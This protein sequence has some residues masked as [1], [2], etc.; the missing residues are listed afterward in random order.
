MPRPLLNELAA[1]AVVA[2]ERSF[3]RAAKELGV[4]PSALSHAMRGLEERL[5]VR[6][7]ARTTRSVATTEA[8]EQLLETL[9]P[10]LAEIDGGIAALH[11]AQDMPRGTVRVTAVKHA[12]E[13]LLMPM[14]PA[15]TARYPG[16]E[17]EIDVDDGLV[18][19]VAQGYDVGIRFSGSVDKDMIAADIGPPLEAVLVA[20]PGYLQGRSEPS[21]PRDLADHRCIAHRR[22]KGGVYPWALNVSGA[23]QLFRPSAALSINDSGLIL[24]AAIAGQGIACVF[25]D[26]A[27]PHLASR[28]LIQLMPASSATLTGY[29][30]YYVGRR[31]TP[32][33]V[34][35]FVQALRTS[36]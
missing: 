23:T 24:R 18:D 21:N 14:L 10:A 8:G 16:I 29:S 2:R 27:A 33:A 36:A 1:F 34:A 4:S 7:L 22:V 30:V 15:F 12:V 26:L 25:A 32:S 9:R 31:Q 3:T 5:A 11:E 28:S 19:I 17:L 13:T 20:A 6:L 35:L